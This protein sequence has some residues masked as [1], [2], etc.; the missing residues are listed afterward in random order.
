MDEFYRPAESRVSAAIAFVVVVYSAR[1]VVGD[2]GIDR[3]VA[4]LDYVDAPG[5]SLVIYIL[6][7]KA[8]RFAQSHFS[9]SLMKK[10]GIAGFAE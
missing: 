7:S 8:L 4:A 9:S 10:S 6:F 5:H 3:L 1:K 2:A